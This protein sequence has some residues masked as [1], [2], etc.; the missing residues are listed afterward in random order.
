M[1]GF[2]EGKT[3]RKLFLVILLC[4]GGGG[5]ISNFLAQRYNLANWLGVLMAILF[6]AILFII[7]LILVSKW[8]D[9]NDRS[10]KQNS[11]RKEEQK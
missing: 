10:I 8:E 11:Y 5:W 1:S 7:A 3:E 4:G 6:T 2:N 9:K